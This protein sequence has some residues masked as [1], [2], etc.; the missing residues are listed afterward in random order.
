ML[1]RSED[2]DGARALQRWLVLELLRRSGS[3]ILDHIPP[4]PPLQEAD[5]ARLVR[6]MEAAGLLVLGWDRTMPGRQT[7]RLGAAGIGVRGT[8]AASAA[9]LQDGGRR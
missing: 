9:A 4:L 5:V 8:A 3:A 7:V 6:E 1:A 2:I